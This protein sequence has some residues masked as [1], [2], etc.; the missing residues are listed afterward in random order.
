MKSPEIKR[1]SFSHV[2]EYYLGRKAIKN[3]TIYEAQGM[4]GC[5][6]SPA[7]GGTIK[8]WSADKHSRIIGEQTG[9][10]IRQHWQ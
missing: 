3:A 1:Q 2:A 7:P 9:G 5:F 4:A 10:Q 6:A 8:L